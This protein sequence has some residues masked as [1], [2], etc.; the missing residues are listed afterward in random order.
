MLPHQDSHG[1]VNENLVK[2]KWECIC[3]LVARRVSMDS[4]KPHFSEGTKR[5]KTL[6]SRRVCRYWCYCCWLHTL[7]FIPQIAVWGSHHV[8]PVTALKPLTSPVLARLVL[9][10]LSM[11]LLK[12]FWLLWK[13]PIQ[14][15]LLWRSC[16]RRIHPVPTPGYDGV[17]C[18]HH[19]HTDLSMD[20]VKIVEDVVEWKKL[21]D[22]SHRH[23]EA[24]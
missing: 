10:E 23:G 18:N 4:Q 16:L 2:C 21:E 17:Q 13:Q 12:W 11:C 8:M 14:L 3:S 7:N 20:T 24:T 9:A 1:D 22:D 5:I 15:T 19:S 6:Q